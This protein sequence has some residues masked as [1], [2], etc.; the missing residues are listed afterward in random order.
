MRGLGTRFRQLVLMLCVP[1]LA[2]SCASV[3]STPPVAKTPIEEKAQ[4]RAAV[5]SCDNQDLP[6]SFWSEISKKHPQVWI[7]L[8]DNVYGDSKSP[9]VLEQKYNRLLTSPEYR[10]FK[11]RL[12]VTGTWDDHD[13]GVNDGGK[14]FVSKKNSKDLFWNFM[15]VPQN[16]ALRLRDGIYRSEMWEISS[17]KVKLIIL[18][19]R[20]N[21]DA[22]KKDENKNYVASNGDML[23]ET[24]WNWLENELTES[25]NYDALV[26][27]NGT[28]V[29]SD[30]HR[31]EKWANFPKSRERLLKLISESPIKIK[32]LLSGDRHF[33]EI[34]EFKFENGSKVTELTS[35]GLTHSYKN[36][37]DENPYRLGPMWDNT[38]YGLMDF[39]AGENS[40]KVE[41]SVVDITTNEKVNT[42]TLE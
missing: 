14:T 8:G 3:K 35:S 26:I 15:E 23:G 27:A 17:K 34:S 20:Y 11:S 31:F 30:K 19:S 41:L 39:F 36:A 7:W 33:G 28:Q 25:E 16:S 10:A 21:R 32:I 9:E 37:Q 5:G 42:V 22:L 4:F 6:Q 18:D 1:I 24:Q 2:I 13:F 29:L 12:R 40:L 38:N